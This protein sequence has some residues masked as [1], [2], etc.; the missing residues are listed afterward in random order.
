MQGGSGRRAK[1]K[2]RDAYISIK[3]VKVVKT[4]D[5]GKRMKLVQA[6][7]A[8]VMEGVMLLGVAVV[9]SKVRQMSFLGHH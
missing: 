3:I 8:A 5:T 4:V 2:T 7:M 6:Q 1:V 9:R